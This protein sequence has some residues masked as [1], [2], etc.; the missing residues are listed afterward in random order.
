[1]RFTLNRISFLFAVFA[2]P[3]NLLYSAEMAE[4]IGITC[5]SRFVRQKIK[6]N[7]ILQ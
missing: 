4:S 7:N 1:M 6:L 5:F 3:K 2:S